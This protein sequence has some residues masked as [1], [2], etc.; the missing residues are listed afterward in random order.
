[1]YAQHEVSRQTVTITE[2]KVKI[3]LAFPSTLTKNYKNYVYSVYHQ[4]SEGGVE[5]ITPVGYNADGVWFEND[6]FSPYGLVSYEK[7]NGDPSPGTGETILLT[8]IAV[9]MLAL[10]TGS[11]AFVVIR[12]RRSDD[13]E[14]KSETEL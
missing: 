5:R 10:A 13:N 12:N 9:I 1:M 8:V 3:C 6:K 14:E 2:G 11:I 7:S 4:K